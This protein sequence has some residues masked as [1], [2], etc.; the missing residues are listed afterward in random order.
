VAVTVSEARPG[1]ALAW[2]RS[3]VVEIRSIA[4]AGVGGKFP[5][6]FVWRRYTVV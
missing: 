1:P 3:V 6:V 5:H 2:R 4:Y